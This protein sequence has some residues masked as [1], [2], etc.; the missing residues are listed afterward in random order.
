MW[1]PVRDSKMFA[2]NYDSAA[3][4]RGHRPSGSSA[5]S[6]A[7]SAAGRSTASPT[8][9][10]PG[11]SFGWFRSRMLGGRTNHWGRISLRFGPDDFRRKSLDG[12]GD[13]W[14]I[15]Y[16]DIK[17]FY[18]EVDKLVGIFG[19]NLGPRPQRA[20]RLLP[21]AAAAALL[22][23][24][25]QAGVG[26]AEHPVRPVAAVDPHEAAQRPAG[27]PL[28]RPVR[29]RLRDAL[30]LLVAVGAHPA[31]DGHRQAARSS[32]TPWRAKSRS[33]TTD[34]RPA[35]PTSTRHRPREP[36]ARAHRRARGE[37]LRVGAAPA[38]FE[39]VEVPAR[40]GELERRRRQVPDRHDR[41][42]RHAASFPA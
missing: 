10:A 13:D 27:V 4:R 30:E 36:R 17:P 38:E 35:S 8:R 21:A 22:R 1:D 32:P 3:P 20:R 42:G 2:W 15:T 24:P 19:T 33:T 31:G 39:V 28:L 29:P 25:D 37:R 14:P 6:T 7:R 41:H 9:T 40:P 26:E 11:S 23:A 5:S 12:L 16:D 18:D 34:S